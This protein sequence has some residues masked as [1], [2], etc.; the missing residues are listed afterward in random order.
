[1]SLPSVP[2]LALRSDWISSKFPHCSPVTDGFADGRD[3]PQS[4]RRRLLQVFVGNDKQ[5]VLD[6]SIFEKSSDAR[7]G[8]SAWR[9]RQNQGPVSNG[10]SA[11]HFDPRVGIPAPDT[12]GAVSGTGCA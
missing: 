12:D 2:R 6:S 3:E 4:A 9:I 11:N 7:T 8:R 1:M 5:N 10:R